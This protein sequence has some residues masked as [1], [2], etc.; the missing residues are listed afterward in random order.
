MLVS[1]PFRSTLPF[2]L[3]FCVTKKMVHFLL[4]VLGR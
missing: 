2:Q 3:A 1:T 4:T